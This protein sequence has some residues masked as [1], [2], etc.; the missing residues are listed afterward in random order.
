MDIVS[1]VPIE[2]SLLIETKVR[3]ADIARLFP[4]QKAQVKFTAYDFTIYGGLAAKVV[5]ISADSII[6]KKGGSFYLVRVKTDRNF[7]GSDAVPLPIIPGMVARV[8]ILTGKKT[9]LDYLLKPI[10]KAR[11]IALTER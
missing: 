8:D 6:D 7:L 1:I 4:G 10:F 3:P 5:H 2:D 9:I 11:Q